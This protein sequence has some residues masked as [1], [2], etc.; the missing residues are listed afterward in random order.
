MR[1]KVFVVTYGGGHVKIAASVIKALLKKGIE[2]SVLGLTSSKFVLDENNIEYKMI[3]DYLFLFK[4]KDKILDLGNEFID[5]NYDSES[6]IDRDDILAYLGFNLWDLSLVNATV[7]KAKTLFIE[8]GK[9]CFYPYY[10][11][12]T[13]IEYEKP[14][15]ILV[16]SEQR[17]EKAAAV[18]CED[19]NIPVIRVIDLLGEEDVIPYNKARLCV[20]NDL[21]KKNLL[22]LNAHLRKESIHITGQPNLEVKYKFKKKEEFFE[23]VKID[24][25]KKIISFF[26]QHGEFDQKKVMAK[27]LE[28]S[29]IK[30]DY[31]YIYKLHPSELMSYYKEF[32]DQIGEN[33]VISKDLDSNVILEKSDIVVTFLS[34]VGLQAIVNGKPVI[35]INLS[36][37][38]YPEDF[39][40]YNCAL[41]VTDLNALDY[42][43]EKMLDLNSD[44]YKEISKHMEKM[45]MP[46]NSADNIADVII[47]SMKERN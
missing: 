18:V 8:K 26:S 39:S 25:Y 12:K 33:F 2:V 5:D 6:L 11:L 37:K 36:G 10:T 4:D 41:K 17:A 23:V 15:A 13:I 43:I 31:L 19:K 28:L 27:M 40:N 16:T 22:R 3:K 14:D 21:V 20:M 32:F 1:K 29:R 44:E 9:Y 42:S 24:K 34:T 7:E 30:G 45:K 46:S 47:N 38:N 35:T